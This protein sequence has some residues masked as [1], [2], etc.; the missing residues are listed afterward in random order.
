MSIRSLEWTAG[1]PEKP[2]PGMLLLY[3]TG[4]VLIVGDCSDLMP[5]GSVAWARLVQPHD[6]EW[7][8]AMAAAHGVGR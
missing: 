1:A 7:I 4:S 5:D 2:E 8:E 6:I 3:S